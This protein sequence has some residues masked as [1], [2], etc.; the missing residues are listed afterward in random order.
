MVTRAVLHHKSSKVKSLS[1]FSKALPEF[2]EVPSKLNSVVDKAFHK[3]LVM[4]VT[5]VKEWKPIRDE[6][7][8]KKHDLTPREL[9]RFKFSLCYR[10]ERL[11]E[12]YLG[13][14]ALHEW[15]DAKALAMLPH[16]NAVELISVLAAY[17][18]TMDFNF[19]EKLMNL[20]AQES[21]SED[22][23]NVLAAGVY[24]VNRYYTEDRTFIPLI[25][26]KAVPELINNVTKVLSSRLIDHIT[27]LT[28]D[29]FSLICAGIGRVGLGYKNI[30]TLY[31]LSDAL[32]E[33]LVARRLSR[34]SFH[35]LID[36]TS[37]FFH[38]NLAQDPLAKSL[39]EKLQEKKSEINYDN[40]IE[41]VQ[42][43]NSRQICPEDLTKQVNSLIKSEMVPEDYIR[44]TEYIF[45]T[46]CKDETLLAGHMKMI[47]A[48]KPFPLH[49]FDRLKR[50]KYHVKKYFPELVKDE[51]VER[52][53]KA[54][55]LY[56]GLRLIKNDEIYLNPHFLQ[57][58][59]W[60]KCL[61]FDNVSQ[62]LHNGH[63]IVDFAVK[64]QNVAIQVALPKYH[65]IGKWEDDLRIVK[66]PKRKFKIANHF[67]YK[68]RWLELLGFKVVKLNYHELSENAE[69]KEARDKVF[70]DFLKPL[71]IEKGM[72]KYLSQKYS[73]FQKK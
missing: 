16:M 38:S 15:L 66:E 39:I 30:D 2:F 64:P 24:V 42:A 27:E 48:N 71:G 3:S 10:G 35:N 67:E 57:V 5:D 20:L 4:N 55:Y 61:G 12:S 47:M 73:K 22:D 53:E 51:F 52:L 31:P 68:C 70:M 21:K 26:N 23:L 33:D 25:A 32:Q 7:L 46:N 19:Y 69:S 40:G 28:D 17:S 60:I 58:K 43:I 37:G 45:N 54:G 44:L 72:N 8:N 36:V 1:A 13:R 63:E 29:Q 41:L 9:A 49:Y 59:K 56:D 14:P 6:A 11:V 18:S 65:L 34:M 62:H 50:H